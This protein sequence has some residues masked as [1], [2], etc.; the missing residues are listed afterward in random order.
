MSRIT[1]LDTAKV[2]LWYHPEEKIVHHRI[3]KF[4]YGEEFYHLLLTGTD[5][6]KKHGARKW[7]SEIGNEVLLRP[8]DLEWGK[9]NW[10]PQTIAAGWKYWGI[11]Q[12]KAVFVQLDLD[13]L[14]KQYA[15]AGINVK[16]FID[17]DKAWEWLVSQE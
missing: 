12:P 14:V 11:V 3:H 7:L 8:E 4:I 5:L 16:F 6:I 9:A 13:P 17:E 10:F 2:T 1:I 15:E